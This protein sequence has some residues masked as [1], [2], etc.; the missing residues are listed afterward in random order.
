[1]LKTEITYEYT[2]RC[3]QCDW[4]T[5]DEGYDEAELPVLPYR[6]GK[7]PNCGPAVPHLL[8]WKRRLAYWWQ[9]RT[10]KR[11]N[12]WMEEVWGPEMAEHLD[13]V[14]TLAPLLSDNALPSIGDVIQIPELKNA[15]PD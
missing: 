11:D 4:F 6:N 7:C 10:R 12:N 15:N 3:T 14:S 2:I 5:N 9:R 8:S 13:F 1:M